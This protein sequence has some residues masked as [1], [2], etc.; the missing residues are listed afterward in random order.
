MFSNFG[1]ADRRFSIWCN[2]QTREALSIFSRKIWR[3]NCDSKLQ[4]VCWEQCPED[5]LSFLEARIDFADFQFLKSCLKIL[6]AQIDVF[7]SCA[8]IRKHIFVSQKCY[9]RKLMFPFVCMANKSKLP[10]LFSMDDQLDAASSLLIV[11][12]CTMNVTNCANNIFRKF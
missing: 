2:L 9:R 6:D 4:N 11:I 10:K 12:C 5:I 3:C 7:I 8:N 1:G